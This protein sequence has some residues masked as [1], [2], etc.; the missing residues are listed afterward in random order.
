MTTL[1]DFNRFIAE[2]SAARESTVQ[3]QLHGDSGNS[4]IGMTVPGTQSRHRQIARAEQDL[5][6]RGVRIDP[7]AR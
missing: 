7:A 2:V 6:R 4:A 1:A 3:D 5:D